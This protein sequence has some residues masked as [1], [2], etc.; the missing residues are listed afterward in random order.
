MNDNLVAWLKLCIHLFFNLKAR[1]LLI[2]DYY[3]PWSSSCDDNLD[4]R[5]RC[6]RRFYFWG[7]KIIFISSIKFCLFFYFF[8]LIK[9]KIRDLVNY[10]E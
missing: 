10:I 7:K 2:C 6:C 1:I 4:Y 8:D 3:Q 5:G 9:N